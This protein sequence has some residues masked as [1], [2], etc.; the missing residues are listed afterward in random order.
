MRRLLL[1]LLVPLL[2]YAEEDVV[3]FYSETL[4]RDS[5][6]WRDRPVHQWEPFHRLKK[7]LP[8]KWKKH[9]EGVKVDW[10]TACGRSPEYPFSFTGKELYKEE[11]LRY[12]ADRAPCDAPTVVLQTYVNG[13]NT[14]YNEFVQ[15][16]IRVLNN[17]PSVPMISPYN[18]SH[19][20]FD[21]IRR[22]FEE[23]NGQETLPVVRTRKFMIETLESL[24]KRNPNLYWHIIAH[25]EG[26][27]IVKRALEGMSRDERS[28]ARAHLLIT[29]L[30]SAEAIPNKLAHTV[31]NIYS[32]KDWLTIDRGHQHDSAYS[33]D[34]VD[35]I[36]GRDER[37]FAG[38]LDHGIVAPTYSSALKNQVAWIGTQFKF[39]ELP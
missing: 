25:S 37:L 12:I 36:S 2:L 30:G 9:F 15:T 6:P 17:G 21:D 18:A 19:G 1:V 33:I 24:H 20:S 3:G 34:I 29:A 22:V 28:L 16:C 23:V 27:L 8:K 14:D 26:G 32:S 38:H 11:V 39:Y 13:I 10:F 31:K 35:C 5:I 4:P 7:A